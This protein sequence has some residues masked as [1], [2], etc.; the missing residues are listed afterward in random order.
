MEFQINGIQIMFIFIRH[1]K[2]QIN[3]LVI[4]DFLLNYL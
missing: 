4:F 1:I 2:F 3:P